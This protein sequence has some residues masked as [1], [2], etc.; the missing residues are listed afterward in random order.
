MESVLNTHSL[1]PTCCSPGVASHVEGES[2]LHG[3]HQL[4]QSAD[5][6]TYPNARYVRTI[7]GVAVV[8][9]HG[10]MTPEQRKALVAFWLTSGAI[11]DE[12]TA[13]QRTNEVVHLGI[14]AHDHIVAVNTCYVAMFDAGSGPLPYWFYRQFVHPRARNVSLMLA[15]VRMTVGYLAKLATERKTPRSL[16]MYLEN[17]KLYKR[18]GQRALS[19][20]DMKLAAKDSSGR[21]V[22]TREF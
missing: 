20:L 2:L 14:D 3:T 12:Q 21:E 17:P 7:S 11:A 18:S 16:A 9:L 15:L 22:W 5:V 10:C 4:A 1:C 19:W 8:N 6:F 13:L